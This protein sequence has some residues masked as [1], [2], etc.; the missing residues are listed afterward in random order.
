MAN[1]VTVETLLTQITS[2]IDESRALLAQGSVLELNGLDQRIAKLCDQANMLT[3][4]D[5]SRY[6]DKLEKLFAEL[7]E[8]GE[9]LAEH[10]DN[11]ATEMKASGS[12]QKAA[13]AY[14]ST[15][16]QLIKRDE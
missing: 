16:H 10:R 3:G 13:S 1:A 5:R 11:V 4:D 12:H 15:G 14:R 9:A 2:Y 8:L 6:A 7:S